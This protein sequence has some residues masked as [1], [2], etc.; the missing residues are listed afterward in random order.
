LSSLS[1]A[2][3]YVLD[4]RLVAYLE[5]LCLR[6]Y[7]AIYAPRES[8]VASLAHGLGV[9]LPRAFRA[10]APQVILAAV[11]MAIGVLIGWVLVKSDPGLFSEIIPRNL[12]GNRGPEQ[13][14]SDMRASLYST[15]ITAENLQN[16]ALFLARHNA[17]V[18][19]MA[20]GLGLA[21][22]LPTIL[23]VL[24]NGVL[25]GAMAAAFDMHG[26]L[27]EFTGWLGVHGVTEL[28]AVIIAAAGGLSLARGILFPKPRETRLASARRH[29]L[30]AGTL[31][32]GAM[33]M[34]FIAA[35]L[36]AFPRQLV[37]DD[38]LRYAIAA[39]TAGLW[40]LYFGFAGR[41]G[42]RDG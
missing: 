12:A 16:F 9:D 11:C 15:E 25:L 24:Y 27:F 14:T 33:G 36:E 32:A 31:G 5:A 2:R 3:A 34:L 17:A 8:L 18:A 20:F 30:D 41:R 38:W 37:Q 26:L 10:L 35:F 6:A 22:G 19:L 1:V 7:L 39:G 13:S 42:S 21:F 29:G 28:G 4:D 23:L 40:A